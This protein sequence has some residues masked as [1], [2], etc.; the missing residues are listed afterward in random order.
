LLA[1]L[2]FILASVTS[3]NNLTATVHDFHLCSPGSPCSVGEGDCDGDDECQGRLICGYSQE[4]G[5]HGQNSCKIY[6]PGAHPLAD[7]CVPPLYHLPV[8]I[9]A[10]QTNTVR[11]GFRNPSICLPPPPPPHGEWMCTQQ[12]S[13]VSHCSLECF[14]R[15]V[16]LHKSVVECDDGEWSEE[17]SGMV[18]DQ[19]AVLVA[20]GFRTEPWRMI[21]SVE[22]YFADGS[23]IRLPDHPSPQKYMSMTL[24]DGAV[25]SCGDGQHYTVDGYRSDKITVTPGHR[26]WK[27]SPHF[28][29]QPY[30]DLLEGRCGHKAA[31][32]LG[33]LRLAVPN[34]S[35]KEG[36]NTCT[37]SS[38]A[39][40]WKKTEGVDIIIGRHGCMVKVAWD[41]FLTLGGKTGPGSYATV[42][43]GHNVIHQA[44]RNVSEMPYHL[45]H[46]GCVYFQGGSQRYV[47]LAGGANE[48][49]STVS[50][51]LA[52]DLATGDWQTFGDLVHPARGLELD[53]LDGFIFA[54][55]GSD[56][57][58]GG[59]DMVQRFNWG[60]KQWEEV[61]KLMTPRNYPA[62]T[63]VPASLFK[64]TKMASKNDLKDII[65]AEWINLRDIAEKDRGQAF[66]DS[67]AFF[68]P[69]QDQE[70]IK[71][72]YKL[73][74]KGPHRETEKLM[75]IFESVQM[76]CRVKTLTK[77]PGY[78]IILPGQ[79]DLTEDVC[80]VTFRGKTF[81]I[82]STSPAR[83]WEILVPGYDSLVWRELVDDRWPGGRVRGGSRQG[84]AV[85]ICQVHNT[86]KI[87]HAFIKDGRKVCAVAEGE[88]E[89]LVGGPNFNILS[90]K[91]ADGDFEVEYGEHPVEYVHGLDEMNEASLVE[92]WE[93]ENKQELIRFIEFDTVTKTFPIPEGW[94]A[95]DVDLDDFDTYIKKLEEPLGI[96]KGLSDSDVDIDHMTSWYGDDAFW[97]YVNE[98]NNIATR[99][100][101]NSVEMG[102]GK[103]IQK[104][105]KS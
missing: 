35:P 40:E 26:C 24:V 69:T 10:L 70:E 52:L 78:E 44:Q 22:V 89:R 67:L 82:I 71:R 77:F 12:S 46:M 4:S 62:V 8:S 56:A 66:L 6:N 104:K 80:K 36:V 91:T 86:G 65:G 18:C 72:L 51:T 81:N 20:G 5:K 11:S 92:R 31:N 9:P 23:K 28:G 42:V 55:G 73:S 49:F 94:E 59:S 1:L 50:T 88:N 95:V 87:G 21:S 47:I 57:D 68:A 39:R 19:A 100:M 63:Q 103:L 84:E 75:K 98:A 54:F 48:T 97:A 43:V 33:G 93:K 17:L 34:P 45:S 83:Y 79:L 16:P 76:L 15:Y 27:T 101:Y 13:T 37:E 96:P 53:I 60:S 2:L 30:R 14:A 102:I 58:S 61:G 85:F 29:W 99:Y 64:N 25:I 3:Q 74:E 90:S 38:S 41:T 7:C 105:I 32:V